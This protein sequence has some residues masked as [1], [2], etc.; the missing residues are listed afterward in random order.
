MNHKS[1]RINAP[2]GP[3][4]A[5]S[6]G[7]MIR[8][9]GIPYARAER[10]AYPTPVADHQEPLEAFDPAPACPQLDDGF[11][12]ALHGI[13][14][15]RIG[16]SEDCQ[17][18][19]V[20]A[21]E[22]HRGLGSKGPVLVW[23][24]GGSYVAGA[25]DA[26]FGDPTPLVLEQNLVVVTVTYRL[27]MLGFLGGDER[28]ANLGLTDIT[29]ALQWVQRNIEAFGGDPR[30][31]T[32]MGESA[33]ADAIAQ[34]MTLPEAPK[35]FTGAWLQS[36]PLGADGGR[37]SMA[38]AMVKA[39]KDAIKLKDVDEVVALQRVAQKAAKKYWRTNG[40][41]FGAQYGK[42]PLPPESMVD[43][44]RDFVAESGI[45]LVVSTAAEE[46]R[47]FV[48]RDNAPGIESH[49][50]TF[51]GGR[52][53]YTAVSTQLMFAGPSDRLVRRHVR[54]GGSA[55]RV[56]IHFNRGRKPFGACHAIYYPLIFDN[57]VG[58]ENAPITSGA[59]SRELA[60]AGRTY[61]GLIGAFARSEDL[62]D[63]Q[64]LS[65]VARVYRVVKKPGSRR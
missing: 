33:G 25:G 63:A 38:R 31:V 12:G 5:L 1:I 22:G 37:Q 53:L 56:K 49:A 41:Y 42:N 19:T 36:P 9:S 13:D 48:A 39:T 40:M 34:L 16:F 28:P 17:N 57:P 8:A 58:W 20:T 15:E 59:S 65:G 62:P 47:L 51:P 7:K 27:G 29:L 60:Q 46:G 26:P 21:P 10:F 6:D 45:R 35:W 32:I 50:I 2:C 54:A 18:L 61:R 55:W 3:I 14:L 23:I 4:H 52:K 30:R 11:W 43:Q 64:V 24:H 44:A